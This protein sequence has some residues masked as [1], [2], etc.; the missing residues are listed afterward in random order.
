MDT[1]HTNSVSLEAD[2]E[3]EDIDK[4]RKLPLLTLEP[5]KQSLAMWNATVV[6]Y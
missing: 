4:L 5:T 3:T 1:F 6:G 2:M